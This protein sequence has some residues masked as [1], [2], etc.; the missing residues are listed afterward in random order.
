VNQLS[1]F[2]GQSI[3]KAKEKRQKLEAEVSQQRKELGHLRKC[4]GEDVSLVDSTLNLKLQSSLLLKQLVH[5]RAVSSFHTSKFRASHWV[6]SCFDITPHSSRFT[7]TE[8]R[9][10]E[11]FTPSSRS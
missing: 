11:S 7:K 1:A 2:C 10:S 6:L 9:L 3:V 5:L 8:W 4:L